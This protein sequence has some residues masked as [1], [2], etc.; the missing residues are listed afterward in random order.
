MGRQVVHDYDV[1]GAEFRDQNLFDIGKERRA[2]HRSVQDHGRDKT[3]MPET[4][5]EGGG[6]PV[7]MGNGC[8][9]AR[10]A[11]STAAQPGHLRAGSA[12]INE[13]KLIRI[14]MELTFEPQLAS[15]FHIFAL[16]L[17]RARC[18][19]LYVMPRLSKNVQ[20]VPTQALTPY[21][22]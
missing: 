21:S 4:G 6:F 15:D 10:A 7:P 12:F 8:T 18:L 1:A 19:F 22:A 13:N 16:L 9:A 20:I 11:Q 14:E 3:V 17:R 2:I 5:R